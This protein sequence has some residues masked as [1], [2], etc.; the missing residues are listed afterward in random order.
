MRT[1]IESLIQSAGLAGARAAQ[2]FP[3][4][5]TPLSIAVSCV[6]RRLVLGERTEEEIESVLEALPRGAGQ[7]GFYSYGELSPRQRGGYCDL[8]NQ[9]MTVTLFDEP[10]TDCLDSIRSSHGSSRA[11]AST[12]TPRRR[13]EQWHGVLERVRAP[14]RKPSRIVTC[15]S[16]RRTSSSAEMAELYRALEDG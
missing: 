15:S 11:S 3:D 7:V 2:D 1:N 14:T 5:G 13:T 12:R 8:H 10:E 9:T 16:A 6:G 4:G